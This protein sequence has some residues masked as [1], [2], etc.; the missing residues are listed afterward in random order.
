LKNKGPT[1]LLVVE[2]ADNLGQD[3]YRNIEESNHKPYSSPNAVMKFCSLPKT[4]SV[5]LK[6]DGE[7][8][9][10]LTS[11][12]NHTVKVNKNS[13]WRKIEGTLNLHCDCSRNF[14][15]SKFDVNDLPKR[16]SPGT[17]ELYFGINAINYANALQMLED[18]MEMKLHQ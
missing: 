18:R 10:V 7:S 8:I 12:N 14:I 5:R 13:I 3:Y 9:D 16:M 15:E 1:F 4:V 17:T 2:H 6:D 11:D